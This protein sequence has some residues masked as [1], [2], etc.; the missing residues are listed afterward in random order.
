MFLVDER[1]WLP[2]RGLCGEKAELVDSGFEDNG[3]VGY[4]PKVTDSLCIVKLCAPNW[5]LAEAAEAEESGSERAK[6]FSLP[7]DDDLAFW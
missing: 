7:L 1:P 4:R 5:E 2:R 3:E 6:V